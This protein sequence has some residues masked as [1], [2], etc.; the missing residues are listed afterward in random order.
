[1]GGAGHQRR[2]GWAATCWL[3]T[4]CCTGGCRRG[5][6]RIAV[7][8]DL[9][10]GWVGFG[11]DCRGSCFWFLV[12]GFNRC[13]GTDFPPAVMPGQNPWRHEGAT[14]KS[15]L[16]TWPRVPELEPEPEPE[17]GEPGP[18][19]VSMSDS[20]GT[21]C[22]SALGAYKTSTGPGLQAASSNQ[23][24]PRRSGASTSMCHRGSTL[25]CPLLQIFII[26]SSRLLFPW[27]SDET[28]LCNQA[29]IENN[30]KIL[31]LC[32][33]LP[34]SE[35]HLGVLAPQNWPG[36]LSITTALPSRKQPSLLD[37]A[38]TCLVAQESDGLSY[39]P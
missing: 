2:P 33:S 39:P 5:Q 18:V 7:I 30:K 1:M 4:A 13:R 6:L 20:D 25:P 15:K 36:L 32:C 28:H 34:I 12:S 3:A 16:R 29:P 14:K 24:G 19:S 9:V 23:G 27:P 31:R 17:P 10:S 8:D 21:G 35:L 26:P 38:C 22:R 37:E 11:L